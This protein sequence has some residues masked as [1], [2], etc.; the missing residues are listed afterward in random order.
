MTQP[1]PRRRLGSMRSSLPLP[2]S[3]REFVEDIDKRLERI[4][5]ELNEYG[6]DPYGLPV[7]LATLEGINS[8]DSRVA[9]MSSTHPPMSD[10]IQILDEQMAGTLDR[11]AGQTEG[12]SRFKRLRA[13]R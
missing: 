11:Y 5:T 10:R 3:I 9:L 6:Y 13:L 2:L 4:P 8:E 12:R 7:H 1:G